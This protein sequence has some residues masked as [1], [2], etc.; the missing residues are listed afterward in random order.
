MSVK[1]KSD[2]STSLDDLRN[3]DTKKR[4]AAVADLR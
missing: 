2:L 1:K 3:E 4:I